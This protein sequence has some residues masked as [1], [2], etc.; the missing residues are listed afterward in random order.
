MPSLVSENVVKADKSKARSLLI[1]VENAVMKC[2]L[3]PKFL[4]GSQSIVLPHEPL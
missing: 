2:K 4:R 3:L 1:T